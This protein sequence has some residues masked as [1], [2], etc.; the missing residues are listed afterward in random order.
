MDRK[1]TLKM[2]LSTM[3]RI[4]KSDIEESFQ[5]P[6]P[7]EAVLCSDGHVSY[8]GYSNDNSLKHIILRA[9]LKQYVKKGVLSHSAC[10]RIAQSN[11]KV[12]GR[13]LPGCFH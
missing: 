13:R 1:N 3:G 6:L 7:N 5:K 9:D 8:K 10:K 2:T 11:E 4:T 12:D